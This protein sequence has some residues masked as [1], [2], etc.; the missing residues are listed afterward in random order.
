MAKYGV[1]KLDKPLIIILTVILLLIVQ[2]LTGKAANAIA[3][4]FSY[5]KFD[6]DNVFAWQSVHHM[7]IL[8]VGLAAVAVLSRPLKS[9]FG[10]QLGDRKK[11]MRYFILFTAAL[12]AISLIYHIITLISEHPVTYGFALNTENVLGTLGFQLLLSGPAEEILYRALP[13]T[14]LIYI[15]GRS[16]TLKWSI[17]S[18]VLL[19]SL[20]FSI[21]HIKWT[22]LPFS[23]NADVFQLFYAFAIGTV[24]GMAFQASR[25]VLYPIL[26]HSISNVLMVGTGYLFAALA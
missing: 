20:L 23:L 13:I 9:N 19:A 1:R 8:I 17:T 6:P 24:Q 4:L 22:L 7:V 2:E 15:F 16:I 12:M 10:F 21:A 3:D 26:M 18:E 5:E 14:V 25:S 11:G